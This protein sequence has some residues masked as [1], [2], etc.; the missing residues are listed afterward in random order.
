M[1]RVMSMHKYICPPYVPPTLCRNWV[2]PKKQG[3]AEKMEKKENKELRR[4]IYQNFKENVLSSCKGT[5]LL[6]NRSTRWN[7]KSP[8]LL[9][10]NVWP[11]FWA[12]ELWVE[13]KWLFCC[14]NLCRRWLQSEA[15][16]NIRT[17]K[18][19]GCISCCHLAYANSLLL[20][21]LTKRRGISFWLQFV[22]SEN[23]SSSCSFKFLWFR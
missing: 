12:A 21:K 8:Y 5:K 19:S 16:K 14:Q 1:L 4:N 20:L 18:T 15:A 3:S 9:A 23:L 13:S 22:H 7:I 2:L 17:G 6:C 10:N 11:C